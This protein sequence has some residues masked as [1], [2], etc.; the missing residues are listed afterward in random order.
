MSGDPM[1]D[2]III[3][4]LPTDTD[5]N[6]FHITEGHDVTIEEVE[7]VLRNPHSEDDWSRSSGRPCASGWTSTGK[8]VF[9]AYEI[10]WA[11][12]LM[13]YPVTAYPL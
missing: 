8:Y 13:I 2:L 12:P 9:V 6:T 4:D 10:A 1:R 11:D 7:E 5:G 3:W